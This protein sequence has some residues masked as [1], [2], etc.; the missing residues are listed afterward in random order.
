[1]VY[2]QQVSVVKSD[3]P[4]A[5]ALSLRHGQNSHNGFILCVISSLIFHMLALHWDCQKAFGLR[6]FSNRI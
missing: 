2:D 4:R 6:Y 1:M 5:A 3:K